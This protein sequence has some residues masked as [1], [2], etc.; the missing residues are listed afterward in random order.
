[1]RMDENQDDTEPLIRYGRRS[2]LL[3]AAV[4]TPIGFGYVTGAV[5][6]AAQPPPTPTPTPTAPAPMVEWIG[7]E[8]IS[9]FRMETVWDCGGT[10]NRCMHTESEALVL[11]RVA[12]GEA[13]NSFGDRVYIM[14]SIKMNAAL[15]FKEALPGWRR[16]VDSWG[17]PTGIYVEALCNGGCQ[18]SP[19]R[20]A[21]QIFYPCEL[22]Q[23]HALRSMLCPTDEQLG[24][25]W[26]T[27]LYAE[28]IVAA[29]L[30]D[31]PEPLKGYEHFRSPTIDG[32]GRFHR[33]DGRRSRIFFPGGNVWRDEYPNDDA[34]WGLEPPPEEDPCSCD[35]RLGQAIPRNIPK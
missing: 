5:V 27:Y 8:L 19:V 25:F 29:D 6:D 9:E 4:L 33:E 26:G 23:H 18:Y 3:L 7:P 34:F 15:G 13:P 24:G 31:F 21:D 28:K 30:S 12:I 35:C 32:V 11:A 1:M 17:P 14:W 20:I 2:I 10:V 22:S 16:P